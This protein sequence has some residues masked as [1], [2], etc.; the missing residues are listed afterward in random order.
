MKFTNLTVAVLVCAFTSPLTAQNKTHVM[1]GFD[2]LLLGAIS[3]SNHLCKGKVTPLFAAIEILMNETDYLTQTTDQE[4]AAFQK[5][6]NVVEVVISAQ[7]C[8]KYQS[9]VSRKL[10]GLD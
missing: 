7:G 8:E 5:G 3:Q 9:N 10:R 2:P 4:Y 1:D 6:E